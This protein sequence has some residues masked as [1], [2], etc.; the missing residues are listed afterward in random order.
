MPFVKLDM[1]LYIEG[2]PQPKGYFNTL[3][4]NEAFSDSITKDEWKK[5]VEELWD[6]LR[7]RKLPIGV[8]CKTQKL[9]TQM[10]RDILWFLQEVTKIIPGD[11]DICSNC[12]EIHDTDYLY[13]FDTNGK[14]YCECCLPHAPVCRCKNCAEEAGYKSHA[15][16]KIHRMYLCKSCKEEL[17]K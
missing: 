4:H 1:G 15:Y 7:N 17:N 3:E 10:S 6:F 9:S 16:S 11:F 12:E 13:Y 2:K 8:E 5:K 14:S